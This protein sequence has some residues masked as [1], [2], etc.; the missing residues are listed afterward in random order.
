M[1][2][3]HRDDLPMELVE[4]LEKELAEK[5]PGV[6]LVCVGDVPGEMP[7][8]IQ[9]LIDEANQKQYE[10]LCHGTCFD[11]G[12]KMPDYPDNFQ[13]IPDDWRPPAG[14]KVLTEVGSGAPAGWICP[15]CDQKPV[16]AQLL[17]D[18]PQT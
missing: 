5:F 9:A 12:A 14:W 15:P 13:E 11:C 1:Q 10:S 2:P 18:G 17:G 8:E 6:K 4:Q 16:G 7:P 3:L